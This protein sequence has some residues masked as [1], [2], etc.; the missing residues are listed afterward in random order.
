MSAPGAACTYH[1]QFVKRDG[2]IVCDECGTNIKAV[3]RYQDIGSEHFLSPVL[4]AKICTLVGAG[5][6]LL[7]HSKGEGAMCCEGSLSTCSICGGDKAW[8]KD[9]SGGP[10]FVTLSP[11]VLCGC[12]DHGFVREGKWVPA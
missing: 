9:V 4:H 10:E 6:F 12:G 5:G 3:P 8:T 11:S 2:A 1:W 7:L